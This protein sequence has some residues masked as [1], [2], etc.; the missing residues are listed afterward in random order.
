[1]VDFD[2]P[3]FDAPNQIFD[4]GEPLLEKK[5]HGISTPHAFMA[6]RHNFSSPVQ[7]VQG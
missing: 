4:V 5:A 2:G 6:I 3:G 1:M 7:L